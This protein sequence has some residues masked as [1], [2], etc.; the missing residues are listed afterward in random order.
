MLTARAM[1][2]KITAMSFGN[3][4]QASWLIPAS[5]LILSVIAMPFVPL[6]GIAGL[7]VAFFML[8]AR[9]DNESGTFLP[10]AVLFVIVLFVMVLLIAG[11]ATI[12][13]LMSGSA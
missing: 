9:M 5:T 1:P 11:L 3:I 10:V 6:F 8:V 4:P 12:H 13:A 2:H 7:V